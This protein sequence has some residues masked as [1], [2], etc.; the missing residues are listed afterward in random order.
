MKE[1]GMVRIGPYW[2]KEGKERLL[3]A[4]G[5]ALIG[6]I[7][8]R[9]KLTAEADT[10][11]LKGRPEPAIPNR[12]VVL[13]Y[14]G[15]LAQGYTEYDAVRTL[16]EDE[17]SSKLNLGLTKG[18]PGEATL[19]QRMD[20]IGDKLRG[21]TL[22]S[23]AD[24]FRKNKVKP[25]ANGKGYVPVDIDVTPMDNSD[26]K[27][28]GVSRTYAGYDG[29]APIV[30]Y[31]GTEGFMADVELREGKQ[32]CQK[33]T[34]DFLWETLHQVW[35]MVGQEAKPLVRM[36]AGNDAAENIGVCQDNHVDF[37]I[38]R[39]LRQEKPEGWEF[40]ALA[41]EFFGREG[42]KVLHPREGK[43][44]HIG[45]VPREINVPHADGYV[46]HET[47]RIVYEVTVRT[48]DRHGQ[49]MLLP[50]VEANTWWT[51]L[52]IPEEDVI[53]Q[54]HAHGE[55]EQ[56]HS[57]LKADMGVERLPS[58]KF[59]T[60]A[61]VMELAMLAYNLLR[62]IGQESLKENDAPVKRPVKRKRLATVIRHL[63]LIA[64]HFTKHARRRCL[65]LGRSNAW[66]RTFLR[67]GSTFG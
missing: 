60:N 64:S 50:Q 11:K 1:A 63:I 31:V 33:A 57:E 8:G 14:I 42:T 52:T 5:L 43:T 28:E 3:P 4:T 32:H 23:N 25:S 17:E 54:Y 30:A 2:V 26:T 21:V 40:D 53:A 48:I 24:M 18:V 46:T 20:Q 55:C 22:R 19:R 12:D 47:V 59:A 51:S 65:S 49:I 16:Q 10:L 27:K 67:L 58:G 56:F 13:T 34:P 15:I 29:F 36:D 39:N 35:A 61:L 45:S 44:V 66:S 37:L 7:L 38:K 6:Q 62:M 9:S 41:N